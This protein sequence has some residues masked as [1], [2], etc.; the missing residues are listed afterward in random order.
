MKYHRKEDPGF[1]NPGDE[2]I[3]RNANMCNME[4]KRISSASFDP[5]SGKCFTCLNGEHKAWESRSGGPVVFV[6]SDQHFPAN[7]PADSAG[8][9]LSILR[10]ENG[11]LS[12]L[13][14]ELLRIASM[15]GLPLKEVLFFSAQQPTCRC[16]VQSTM[17][18]SGQ[19]TGTG[20]WKDWVR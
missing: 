16:L 3:L 2:R 9:C 1:M 10:L 11:T 4:V 7:I 17:P 5:V 14:D 15:G 6:L 13:A 12:E 18:R 19:R 20:C 8:E